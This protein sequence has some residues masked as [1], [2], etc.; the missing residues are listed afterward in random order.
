MANYTIEIENI[1]K[2]FCIP[3]SVAMDIE[4]LRS[5]ERRIIKAFRKN[6]TLLDFEV[7]NPSLE[8]QLS[9]IEDI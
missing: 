7:Q 6:S 8:A 9:K 2:E 1:V 5:Y 3:S 4:L